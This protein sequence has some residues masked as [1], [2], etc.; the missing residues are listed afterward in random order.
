MKS[1][2]HITDYNYDLQNTT[3][4]KEKKVCFVYLPVLV[5]DL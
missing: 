2:I 3:T 4:V 1:V 5:S